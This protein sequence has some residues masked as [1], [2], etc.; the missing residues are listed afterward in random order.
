MNVLVT[1]DVRKACVCA[2]LVGLVKIVQSVH[3]KTAVLVTVFV[4]QTLTNVNVIRTTL[5]QTVVSNVA[6]MTA[7]IME[8]V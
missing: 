1:E 2:K 4:I 3:V 8:Y 5:D 6:K 7:L